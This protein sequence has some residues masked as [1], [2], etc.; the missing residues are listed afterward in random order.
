MMEN[1]RTNPKIK[2][3]LLDLFETILDCNDEKRAMFWMDYAGHVSSISVRKAEGDYNTRCEN[4][5]W[6]STYTNC[7]DESVEDILDDI[8]NKK[9]LVLEAAANWTDEKMAERQAANKKYRLEALKQEIAKL[10]Q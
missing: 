7:N 1:T 4:L 5:G 2:A 3:A 9:A 6:Y 10:E 8:A